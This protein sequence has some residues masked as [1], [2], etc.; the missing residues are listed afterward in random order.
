MVTDITQE[1]IREVAV[2]VG[3]S[4]GRGTLEDT[5]ESSLHELCELAKT[6]G[7]EVAG[8][9]LQNVK[10]YD[11][12]TY[13]G[14][15]KV[16]ELKEFIDNNGVT[17]AVFDDELSGS[18]TRNLESEL[19]IKVIDRS[20]LILDIFAGRA[21]SREG[22]CQVE[23]AQ[24]KY[25]LPRLSGIG[26][27]LSRL[28]GGIGTRGPGETK[29]ESDRRH[30]RRR[31]EHLQAEL[32]EIEK[33]RENIRKKRRKEEIPVV[34]LVGYTNAGKSSLMNALTQADTYVENQLF[35]TLD[36]LMRKMRVSD[37]LEIV[38]SDTVGFIRKLPHH[39]VEAFKS[40]LEETLYADLILHV[41]DSAGDEVERQMKVVNGILKD[42]GAQDKPM[43]TVFNK[44]DLAP[45]PIV[46]REGETVCVSA[47]T[48]ANL[49]LLLEKIDQQLSGS[50]LTLSLMIPYSEGKLLGFLYQNGTVL[51]EENTLE[52]TRI[53]VVLEDVYL[54]RVQMFVE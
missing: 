1:E 36:P 24:L 51:S 22:K 16:Q 2:I 8:V 44:C 48:G 28:G 52:G 13:I 20:R 27:D 41:V 3:A 33:H 26:G 19:G 9:M 34:A 14:S 29:L 50:K 21:T 45:E 37:T 46:P 42:L 17:V 10:A 32:K 54:H 49:S 38:L 30:V 4:L 47:K 25:L 43:I 18:V 15:G 5:D 7:A 53:R 6:A 12:R 39:L 23:L 31:I 35:A 40:T 11:P